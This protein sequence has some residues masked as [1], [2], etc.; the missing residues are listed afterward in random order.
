MKKIISLALVLVLAVG[1]AVPASASEG[2][3]TVWYN[4][5]DYTMIGDDSNIWRYNSTSS[6]TL[7]VPL[8]FAITPRYIELVIYAEGLTSISC[9]NTALTIDKIS[10][11]L[12]RVYGI[13]SSS[14][15]NKFSF[16]FSFSKSSGSVIFYSIKYTSFDC[17]TFPEVGTLYVNDYT[18]SHTVK[19]SSSGNSASYTVPWDYEGGDGSTSITTW[20]SVPNWRRYDYL[21]ISFDTSSQTITS[22]SA[23]FGA[24]YVPCDLTYLND[25]ASSGIDA[26]SSYIVARLDLRG[27]DRTKTDSLFLRFDSTGRTGTA[28]TTLYRVSGYVVTDP[29]SAFSIWM[30]RLQDTV[31]GSISSLQTSIVSSLSS[32]KS[33]METWFTNIRDNLNTN[34][35]SLK[36]HLTS[37]FDKDTTDS[38]E[39]A[40]SIESQ[41]G[42]IDDANNALDSVTK[43]DVDDI[44]VSLDSYVDSEIVSSVGDLFGVFLSGGIFST[45]VYISLT[46]ALVSFVLYGKRS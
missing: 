27:L 16:D 3:N 33:S 45:M 35:Q 24:V 7:S 2:D 5:L 23:M 12:C 34:F 14:D 8:P 30:R 44:N 17:R 11:S 46:L 38:D 26:K 21:D 43:P 29:P 13:L 32:F 19:M 42:Q 39:F 36:D 4:L 25:A 41:V 18:G 40:A 31:S 15:V 9:N 20:I 1:F 10:G 6:K 28:T 37:L 22:I